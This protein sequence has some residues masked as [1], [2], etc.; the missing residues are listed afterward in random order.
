MQLGAPELQHALQLHLL[1]RLKPRL[2]ANLRAT[3]QCLKLLVDTAPGAMWLEP[4]STIVHVE[5]LPLAGDGQAVQ[6]R[7][8]SLARLSARLASGA[9]SAWVLH[10][11]CF[12]SASFKCSA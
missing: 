9:A 1:P 7:L 8:R 11:V 4:A 5:S 12:S 10:Q 2:L 6:A 3:C